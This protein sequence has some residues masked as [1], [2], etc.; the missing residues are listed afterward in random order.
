MSWNAGRVK[1]LFARARYVS[2]VLI[3]SI[4]RAGCGG[5]GSPTASNCLSGGSSDAIINALAHGGVAQ[6]CQG[7]VFSADKP[8]RVPS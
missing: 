7:A 4:S 5:G 1:R 3:A 8:M 2:A 6:L